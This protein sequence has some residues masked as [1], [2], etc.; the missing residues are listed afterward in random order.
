MEEFIGIVRGRTSTAHAPPAGTGPQHRAHPPPPRRALPGAL[1]PGA[2]RAVV[3]FTPRPGHA[4][5]V[6]LYLNLAAAL[7]VIR[8]HVEVIARVLATKT[9]GRLS[10][11]QWAGAEEQLAARV[12]DYT[13]ASCTS[14]AQRWWSCS[15]G[16]RTTRP[17]AT[18]PE[19]PECGGHRPHLTAL[20]RSRTWRTGPARAAAP[21][22]R[23]A[24]LGLVAIHRGRVDVPVVRPQRGEH[25]VHAGLTRDLPGPETDDPDLAAVREE[26][27]CPGHLPSPTRSR[28]PH[29]LVRS[30]TS[31]ANSGHVVTPL[32]EAAGQDDVEEAL[33]FA[34]ALVSR[35]G[36]VATQRQ[37]SAVE[38]RKTRRGARRLCGHGRRPRPRA[39]HR[40]R[41]DVSASR[42]TA[43]WARKAP[44][45]PRP[46]RNAAG[47][48]W[49]TPST[50]P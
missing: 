14:G 46:T 37:N 3:E 10:P 6:E 11:Q 28:P 49:S 15:T 24:D 43:S 34:G 21:V 31:A 2:V 45:G 44:T 48:G 12:A 29:A 17:P 47:R 25:G 5:L 32:P 20:I 13:R 40:R 50:A 4:A 35:L 33:A 7:T 1:R 38:Q 16:R 22:P 8:R 36:E 27:H 23:G 39:G 30:P 9:A 19:V 42:P 26:P 41:P 18:G